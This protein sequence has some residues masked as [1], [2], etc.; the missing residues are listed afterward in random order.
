MARRKHTEPLIEPK[1]FQSIEEIDRGIR[2]LRRRIAEVEGLDPRKL[3]HADQEVKNVEHA[4]RTTILDTFGMRSPEYREHQGYVIW[5]GSFSLDDGDPER[6]QKFAAGIPKTKKFL[7][8]LIRRLEEEK[9]DFPSPRAESAYDEPRP[10]PGHT[11]TIGSVGKLALGD[12]TE[13]NITVVAILDS[14]ADAIEKAPDIPA[15]KKKPLAQK[16]RDL[17]K[18]PWIVRLGSGAVLECLKRVLSE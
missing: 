1:V 2:K 12:I 4:I 6:H 16:I 17:A 14:V 13:Q 3:R 7:E 15:D 8:G 18:D 9:E 10:T 5:D 11:V